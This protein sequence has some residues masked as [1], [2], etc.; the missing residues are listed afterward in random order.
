MWFAGFAKFLSDLWCLS[1]WAGG[2]NRR[3]EEAALDNNDHQNDITMMTA[4][5]LRE[6]RA[7]RQPQTPHLGTFPNEAEKERERG[8]RGIPRH[9]FVP[10][11]YRAAQSVETRKCRPC[12][13]DFCGHNECQIRRFAITNTGWH[14]VICELHK[15]RS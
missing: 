13:G 7:P 9:R 4:V 3:K 1:D 11:C 14:T 2:V 6:G 5:T 10:P 12:V 15:K 8:E